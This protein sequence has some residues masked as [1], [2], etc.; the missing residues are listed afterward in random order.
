[1][2][3]MNIKLDYKNA[4]NCIKA[5]DTEKERA[6]ALYDSVETMKIPAQRRGLPK[7]AVA[8]IAFVCVL[9]LGGGAVWATMTSPAVKSFFFKNN[10]EQ[11][12]N[13]YTATGTV[14]DLG[15][16]EA[17]YEGSTYDKTLEVGYLS[18]RFR[19]KEGNPLDIERNAADRSMENR[20]ADDLTLTRNS[21][22]VGFG[23]NGEG[24]HLIL[25]NLTNVIT[26]RDK[27]GYIIR[28]SR[29]NGDGTSKFAGKDLK[30]LMLNEDRFRDLKAEVG[31]LD[32][33]ELC[34]FHYDV[35]TGT[36]TY[37]YD[38]DSMQPEV[39]EI[40]N[41]YGPCTVESVESPAQVFNV[42]DLKIT[43]GRTD[44][45]IECT[46]GVRTVDSFTMIREDGTRID[47]IRDT[48]D[49]FKVESLE[50]SLGFGQGGGPG[51]VNYNFGF[52]LGINEHVSIEANGRVYK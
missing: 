40:L 37:N 3:E 41:G 48:A 42:E 47:F 4:M 14:Y 34:L 32:A 44:I 43:V 36:V 50:S 23:L 2:D 26:I 1:M 24:V 28:F 9:T 17:V 21:V 35:E 27:D 45:M 49:N 15:N 8:M 30:F 12:E 25:M 20:Y 6:V 31:K 39:V 52:V 7:V 33:D 22:S 5:S 10:D 46:P 13:V 18:F 38:W 51:L 16:F 19:D 29:L 11:F